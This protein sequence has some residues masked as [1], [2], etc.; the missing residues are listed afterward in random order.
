MPVSLFVAVSLSL[1][2]S[3]FVACRPSAVPSS[4][5]PASSTTPVSSTTTV[6]T[7]PSTTERLPVSD[8]YDP[9]A[10]AAAASKP[11]GAVSEGTM[12][13][14]DGRVRHYRLFVPRNLPADSPVPLLVALLGQMWPR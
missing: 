6:S 9:Y 7:S 3:L 2:V 13:T 12:R 11:A 10:G 8:F 14:A 4:T 5:T 1:A